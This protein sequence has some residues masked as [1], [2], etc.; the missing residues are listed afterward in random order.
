MAVFVISRH[1]VPEIQQFRTELQRWQFWLTAWR[2]L[3]LVVL[4]GGYAHWL[5][6]ATRVLKLD[7]Q[8]QQRALRQRGPVALIFVVVEL[9][10][11]QHGLET[12]GDCLRDFFNDPTG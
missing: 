8:Q 6:L 12:L 7:A 9:A 1:S 2:L 10:F 3:L 5:R 11:G 4:I